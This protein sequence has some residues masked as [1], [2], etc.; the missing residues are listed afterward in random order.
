MS[1]AAI[2]GGGVIGGGWAARFALMGWDVAVFD[3][4]PDAR[5][6]LDAVMARARRAL[7]GLYDRAL[8]DEGRVTLHDDMAQAL[9]GAEWIQ[10]SAPEDLKLKQGLIARIEEHAAPSAI[11]A[12]STSGFRPSQLRDGARN[13]D[14]IVVAH[15]FNPVYLLPLVEL[16]T[17]DGPFATR[18]AEILRE[19]GMDPLHLTTEIDAHVADRL[20]ESIW[21]EALWLVRDGIATTEQIDRAITHGFGL[22]WA[23]MGLFETY[24]MAGGTGGMTDFL[25][26]FAPALAWPWSRLTDVPEMDDALA[27][28]IGALSDAQAGG[29]TVAELEETRD[30]NLVGILRALRHADWG[31]GKHLKEHENSRGAPPIDWSRPIVTADRVVPLDW[32][33]FNGHMTE[34]RYLLAFADATERLMEF[35]GCDDAY[36]AAGRS[37]FTAETHI[38]HVSEIHAGHRFRIETQAL[39]SEGAKL[40][41]FQRMLEGDRLL[42]TGEHFL[43]HVSL[44][45]RR[46]APPTGALASGMARLAEG[47]RGLPYPEGAGRAVG[48]RP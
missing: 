3:P 44:E 15:P 25:K 29:R 42:A 38:R 9:Q 4:S 10:E 34:S 46:P 43:L 7:P 13:P 5:E 14:R 11:I 36:I 27:T 22:R 8:G 19:I 24:R 32:T 18:A 47:H 28:R 30:D 37:F 33:D 35:I 26:Q 21:R 6:A 45:T 39:Q 2:V 1:R 20:L 16:V 41:V 31:V 40:H 17:E 23:Q 12:S 48:Q